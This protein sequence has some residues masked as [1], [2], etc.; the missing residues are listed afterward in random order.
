M[1]KKKT[2]FSKSL[3]RSVIAAAVVAV[4]VIAI[5][6]TNL[7]LPVKYLSAYL[8][9][10]REGLPENT[11]RVT[12]V[13]VGYGDCI[14]AEFSDGKVLLIDGGDGRYSHE[15]KLLTL[16]NRRGIRTIDYLVCTS[17]KSEHCGG[18]AEILRYKEVGKIY[19][20]YCTVT[21]ITEE[22]RRFHEEAE[23]SGAQ[24]VFCE[25]G[26][27]ESGSDWSFCFLS[28][29]VHTAEWEGS[30]YYDMNRDPTAENVNNAS[31]V[32]WLH[33]AGID[34]LLLSDITAKVADKLV[35]EYLVDGLKD[36]DGVSVRLEDCNVVMTALH[37]GEEGIYARLWDLTMPETAVISVGENGRGAP[38]LAALA[39]AQGAVGEELYRTDEQG[40]LTVVVR[41]GSY[42]IEKEKS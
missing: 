8:C 4:A 39:D 41:D 30:E 3:I 16:L 23:R 22:Y 5:L 9:L 28:P 1:R 15:L 26:E 42:V 12:F 6:I 35:R 36:P 27:G 11:S 25:F 13:D 38:S 2:R 29:A 7:F 37:G 32:I 19:A 18:L 10:S 33:S 40:T 31:A 17:V 21:R 24:R 34:F 14:L 20:P